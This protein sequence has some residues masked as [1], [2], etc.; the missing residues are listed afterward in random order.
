MLPRTAALKPEVRYENR[1]AGAS[2]SSPM[3][4][5]IEPRREFVIE[6]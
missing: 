5:R 2:P 4:E 3:G 6:F 1:P